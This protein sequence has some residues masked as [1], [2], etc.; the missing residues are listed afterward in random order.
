MKGMTQY[1]AVATKIRGMRSHLLSD[2]EYSR[3]ANSRNVR[4]I[5]VAL[6]SHPGYAGALESLD[7]NDMRRED[8]ERLIARSVFID[9]D[10]ISHFLD[11]KQKD[12]LNVY[13]TRSDLR[14]INDVLRVIFST[15]SES[16][17]L[18]A[19]RPMFEDSK[20]FDFDAVISSK[21]VDDLITALEGSKYQE[22]I[23]QVREQ[24]QNPVLF[25]Y[26]TSVNRF[27]FADF[28]T[29]LEKFNSS[30]DKQSLLE[31]HGIE[32]D[33]LNILWVYRTKAYY[34][35]PQ[36]NI[37]RY[38]IP[39]SYKLKKRDL[40]QMVAAPDAEACVRLARGTYYGKYIDIQNPKALEDTY[41]R[42]V[43]QSNRKNRKAYPYSF[44][45]IEAYIFEK[46]AEVDRLVSIIE[47]VR[48]GYSSKLILDV[49]KIKNA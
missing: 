9:I 12:F 5:A 29:A 2:E 35:V 14:F 32:I 39:V 31:V 21:S 36:K 30:V 19:Y 27:L 45:V 22:P 43:T 15:Y 47:S 46:R 18:E 1:G 10:K 24:I 16:P 3:L 41:S 4:E 33:L 7:V 38:L 23:L 37:W 42:L 40:A 34:K 8:L 25:D 49:L 13:R 26:E 6:K 28:W 44:A 20:N 11:K 48:Y 17:N